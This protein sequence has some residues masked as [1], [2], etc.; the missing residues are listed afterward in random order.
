MAVISKTG[1]GTGQ[2]IQAEHVTRIID[3]LDG[4]GA[5]DVIA[6]GSFTGSFVG[7]LTGTASNAISSSYATTSSYALNSAGGTG[8]PFTG[9]AQ[10]TGSL[11]V[12]GSFRASVSASS[13][14]LSGNFTFSKILHT[15]DAFFHPVAKIGNSSTINASFEQASILPGCSVLT[16]LT[17]NA[18]NSIRLTCP[19]IGSD[20]G[21]NDATKYT[22]L[23]TSGSWDS[24]GFR[25]DADSG[26][27]ID[28][29]IIDGD[30]KTNSLI[31]KQSIILYSGSS[32]TKINLE[33]VGNGTDR[34]HCV[35]YC[36]T[37]SQSTQYFTSI[38]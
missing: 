24:S 22:F 17:S 1:I 20:I 35:I 7:Q 36:E 18:S 13:E 26:D 37:G 38:S 12:T 29:L 25:I 32:A 33:T 34:W 31:D 16:D 2:P 30:S 6:T 4:T 9:S 21:G 5:A 10:I 28:T 19:K 3:A 8:F 15:R 27:K 14:Y 11:S 23:F